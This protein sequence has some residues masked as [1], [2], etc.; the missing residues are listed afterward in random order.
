MKFINVCFPVQGVKSYRFICCPEQ[1]SGFSNKKSLKVHFSIEIDADYQES[2]QN[3][4]HHPFYDV[5]NF[6][7]HT[8]KDFKNEP[9]RIISGTF[10]YN[11]L[12]KIL[13]EYLKS[14]D[15]KLEKI[16]KCYY[17]RSDLIE[18]LW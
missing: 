7:K 1:S 9:L 6:M 12:S 11:C 13:I 4:Y 8:V 10:L 17:K 15:S 5:Y 2:R 3:L 16:S 18:I 14:P